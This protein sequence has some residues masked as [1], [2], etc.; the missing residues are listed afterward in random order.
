MKR[1]A[2]TYLD[3]NGMESSSSC[4]NYEILMA[5]F[6]WRTPSVEVLCMLAWAMSL[7]RYSGYKVF[8][9]LKKY[10]RGGPLPTG[11]LSGK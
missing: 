7:A 9:T 4:Q 2:A 3:R 5:S 8:K 11:N 6:F 1:V 10:A